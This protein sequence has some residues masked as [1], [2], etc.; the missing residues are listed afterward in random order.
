MKPLA[1]R[2][3]GILAPGIS[4]WEAAC[5]V[6]SGCKAYL[7][8]PLS[9]LAP[10]ILPAT[11]RRRSSDSTKLA[12]S[13]AQQ[14]VTQGGIEPDGMVSV[15]SSSIGDPA[16]L[17]NLCDELSAPA[18]MVSPTRFHNSVHNAPVGYWSIATGAMGAAT[19]LAAHESSFSAGLL[20]AAAQSLSEQ[21]PVLFICYDIPYPLPLAACRPIAETF[22]VAMVL[23][24]A[25]SESPL[26][27]IAVDLV[28]ATV[29]STEM[30]DERLETVRVGNP[31]ARSLPLLQLIASAQAGEI[32]LAHN[33]GLGLKVSYLRDAG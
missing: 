12:I 20:A 11:E 5:E 24:P 1:I 13:V 30:E 26:G 25:T 2:G 7:P 15:F 3:L 4:G 22:A 14:A 28:P 31:A 18:P 21:T 23:D 16:I 10:D 29:A 19:S 17:H 8:E 33:Q 27:C 32:V 9:R 6:L